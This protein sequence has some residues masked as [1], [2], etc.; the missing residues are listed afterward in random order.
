MNRWKQLKKWQKI[1]IIAFGLFVLIG[2]TA[3]PVEETAPEANSE[4]VAVT[5]ERE[6]KEPETAKQESL[7]EKVDQQYKANWG[8]ESYTSFLIS[9]DYP[10]GSLVG[11]INKMEDHSNG[12]VLVKVQTDVTKEQA[13]GLA[14][15]ILGMVGLDIQELDSVVV[16]GVDGLEY[17]A[18]RRD[19]PALR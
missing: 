3:P 16:A 10:Q 9:E 11:Y 4:P 14:K 13:E 15:N 5:E 6:E 12:T 1:T 19:I 17:F 2:I 8:I 7:A 18:S